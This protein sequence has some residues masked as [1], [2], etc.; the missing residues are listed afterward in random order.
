MRSASRSNGTW[1]RKKGVREKQ[2][3]RLADC[4]DRGVEHVQ[5]EQKT[6]REYVEDIDKVAATLEPGGESQADRQEKFKE[7]IDRF[8]RT[9]DPIRQHMARLMISFLA[10]LLVVGKVRGDQGQSRSRAMVSLAQKTREADSR[11]SPRGD[12]DRPRRA[13]ISPRTGR[14]HCASRAIYPCGVVA[15]SNRPRTTLPM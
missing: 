9:G 3:G 6:I 5:A 2:L 1:T 11:S 8:E 4:I 15:V 13:D 10:G 14:T 12:S 7:L